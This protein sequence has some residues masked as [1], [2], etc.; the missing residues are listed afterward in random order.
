MKTDFTVADEKAFFE[1][2]FIHAFY[3]DLKSYQKH[4]HNYFEIMYVASGTA[5]HTHDGE[6]RTVS[7]GDYML[8]DYSCFHEYKAITD[9]FAVINCLFLSKAIDKT[10][11]DCTDF[12]DLLKSCQFRVK[13][14]SGAPTNRFFHD[15]SGKIGKLLL[16]MCEEC[17]N[18]STGYLDY[19][20]TLLVQTLV[21]LLRNT[22]ELND[23]NYS[24]AVA[25]TIKMIDQNFC[26]AVKLS[27]IASSLY[28]SVPYLSSKFKE[29]T[30]LCFNDY[31]KQLRIQR[32]CTLLSSTQLKIQKIAEM[33]GYGDYKRFG[34]I[35]KQ[36]TG[37]SPIKY[38]LSLKL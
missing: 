34:T 36:L 33:S 28:L 5:I 25:K 19:M 11:P 20:K 10:I 29:E 16:E 14:I 23:R 37:K 30:G 1:E 18:M 26:E 24:D 22:T 32:A 3:C 8:M 4:S 17:G 31:V 6:T 7:A 38:R 12:G 27:D 2:K 15:D 13:V 9:D 21:T 35:F